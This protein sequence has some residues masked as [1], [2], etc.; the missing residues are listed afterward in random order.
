MQDLAAVKL[1]HE[2]VLRVHTKFWSV[3]IDDNINCKQHFA[4]LSTAVW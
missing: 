4:E 1:R 2:I 3:L